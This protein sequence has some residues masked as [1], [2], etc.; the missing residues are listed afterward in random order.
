[1]IA[2]NPPRPS[3]HAPDLKRPSQAG[4]DTRGVKNL[5]AEQRADA[6]AQLIPKL[7]AYAV[8]SVIDGAS[9]RTLRELLQ[10]GYTQSATADEF[11]TLI[12]SVGDAMDV[13][14]SEHLAE[15]LHRVTVYVSDP[16]RGKINMGEFAF[17]AMR[18]VPVNELGNELG[19]VDG[20]EEAVES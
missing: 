11:A 17:D 2:T 14:V 1:M 3:R 20:E 12:R 8:W 4:E 19:N 18:T 15:H 6:R 5:G 10:Q 7:K 13:R 9:R 16:D